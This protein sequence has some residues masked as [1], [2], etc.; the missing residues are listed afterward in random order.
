MDL[1]GRVSGPRARGAIAWVGLG[2]MF[3]RARDRAR[4]VRTEP[5]SAAWRHALPT[6][7]PRPRTG[8]PSYGPAETSPAAI[9]FLILTSV[10]RHW[11]DEVRKRPERLLS[12]MAIRE[13]LVAS[14]VSFPPQPHEA[15]S[16][17]MRLTV[18]TDAVSV[19][20][21]QVPRFHKPPANKA[22]FSKILVSPPPLSRTESPSSEART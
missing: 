4:W 17:S 21:Q 15:N 18:T 10:N 20:T 22:Q 11:C 12:I 5:R 8:L 3:V 14:A 2:Q 16:S 13:D 19:V 6:P 1:I 7:L 9:A